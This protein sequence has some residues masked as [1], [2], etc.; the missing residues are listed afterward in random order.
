MKRWR[1][2]QVRKRQIESWRVRASVGRGP[3][4][5]ALSIAKAV[6]GESPLLIAPYGYQPIDRE[7][8]LWCQPWGKLELAENRWKQEIRNLVESLL[9]VRS[10][11]ELLAVGSDRFVATKAVYM[12]RGFFDRHM[13]ISVSWDEPKVLDIMPGK[14]A[15]QSAPSVYELGRSVALEVSEGR[16]Q[17]QISAADFAD[18]I[19][20]LLGY[21]AVVTTMK[22]KPALKLLAEQGAVLRD[23]EELL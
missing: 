18:M 19:E 12:E 8:G 5:V 3:V 15:D 1:R 22:L 2:E 17:L 23:P 6:R 16:V 11:K 4:V 13:S 7:K 9:G 21:S 20:E 10:Y 14:G